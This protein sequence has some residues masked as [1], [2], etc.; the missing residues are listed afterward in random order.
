[1]GAVRSGDRDDVLRAYDDGI[2]S[3]ERIS[4]SMGDYSHPTPCEGWDGADL[5][6][7]LL[8]I[9]RYYHRLLDAACVKHPLHD[10]PRG[11]RLQAMNAADVAALPD[12]SGPQ[13]IGEFI[14]LARQ[15]R[16][17][18]AGTDWNLVLGYWD[19]VGAWTI[20]EHT[21]LAVIEWHVHAWDLAWSCGLDHRP[22]APDIVAA[23]L[24]PLEAPISTDGDQWINTLRATGRRP[25]DHV[26]PPLRR[27]TP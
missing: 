23:G 14:G 16:A 13:R 19:G 3:I 10:L 11:A 24:R 20:G 21:G 17:R 9:A 22:S 7:H 8:A 4:V 18:L 2:A 15:Y 12:K 6:G 5:T 25:N 1:V 27:G 26:H